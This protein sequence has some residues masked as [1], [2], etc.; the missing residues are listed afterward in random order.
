MFFCFHTTGIWHEQSRT[1]RDKYVEVLWHNI[2]KGDEDNFV[3]MLD[4]FFVIKKKL[5]LRLPR[6]S[7]KKINPKNEAGSARD[8][9]V[10]SD[11]TYK[12]TRTKAV[13]QFN[14]KRG[15]LTLINYYF[16]LVLQVM[17]ETLT[18]MTMAS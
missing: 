5:V 7:G 17:R 14:N 10:K 8:H 12:L 16:R 11:F 2:K 1:D 9:I 3:H 4:L 18:S 6:A 13:I 15:E